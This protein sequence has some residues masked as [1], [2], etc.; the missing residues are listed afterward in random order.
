MNGFLPAI[1]YHIGHRYAKPRD[2]G[3]LC[4][5]AWDLCATDSLAL[6][7][8]GGMHYNDTVLAE[9]AEWQTPGT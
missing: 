4:N 8:S 3:D 7:L 1:E 6:A 2:D 5:P 9:V